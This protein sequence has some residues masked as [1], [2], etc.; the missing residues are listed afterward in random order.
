[1]IVVTWGVSLAEMSSCI[2]MPNMRTFIKKKIIFKY[3]YNKWFD[4]VPL[5]TFNLKFELNRSIKKK[6]NQKIQKKVFDVFLFL[7]SFYFFKN[8]SDF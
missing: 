3:K 7:I 8:W 4:L 5:L 6:I 1:M 2:V